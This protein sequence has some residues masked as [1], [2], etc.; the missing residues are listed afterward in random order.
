MRPCGEGTD[1]LG[2]RC[3]APRQRVSLSGSKSAASLRVSTRV[4]PMK[5]GNAAASICGPRLCG[6]GC[7]HARADWG[8]FGTDER[9]SARSPQ[10]V[11]MRA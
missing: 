3:S 8:P 2:G 10:S 1:R 4:D 5:R 9:H 6:C 11:A 7:E